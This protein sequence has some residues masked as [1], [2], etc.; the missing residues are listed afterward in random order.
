MNGVQCCGCMLSNFVIHSH[1]FFSFY[2]SYELGFEL[3]SDFLPI[4][5][6]NAGMSQST[7]HL[8]LRLRKG[9]SS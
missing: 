2:V 9:Y 6:H 5:C 4:L 8:M 3:G 7:L 1:T